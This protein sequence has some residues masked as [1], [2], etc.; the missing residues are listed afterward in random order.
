MQDVTEPQEYSCRTLGFR[1]KRAILGSNTQT[2]KYLKTLSYSEPMW[3]DGGSAPWPSRPPGGL[4][5]EVDEAAG[6]E[7]QVLMRRCSVGSRNGEKQGHSTSSLRHS[8]AFTNKGSGGNVRSQQESLYM[9]IKPF[10]I[11]RGISQEAGSE[12]NKGLF[13][14]FWAKLRSNTIEY[15]IKVKDNFHNKGK[16]VTLTQL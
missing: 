6:D 12:K 8:Q 16:I 3:R 5:L 4:G 10:P 13:G 11:G 9:S 7:I 1:V 14:F 2:H 15:A